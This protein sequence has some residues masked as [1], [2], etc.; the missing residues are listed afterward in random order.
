MALHGIEHRCEGSERG[1]AHA[2]EIDRAELTFFDDRLF[3]SELLAVIDFDLDSFTGTPLDETSEFHV[4]IR[5]RVVRD[6]GFT[7]TK[8]YLRRGRCLRSERENH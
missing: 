5:R 6:M 1:D 2:G 8:H 7:K 3:F 4:A